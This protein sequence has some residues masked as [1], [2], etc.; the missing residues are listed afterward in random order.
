MC[1]SF[2]FF[3]QPVKLPVVNSY[4]NEVLTE[5]NNFKFQMMATIPHLR[6]TVDFVTFLI[7]FLL[8]TMQGNATKCG[9]RN[10]CQCR[11]VNKSDIGVDCKATAINVSEACSVCSV[12]GNVTS[13]DLG[14]T[15]LEE[16]PSSCFCH[17]L[18]LRDL[19]LAA[20]G[21]V[22]LKSETF[23]GLPKLERL[24]LSSNK[25]IKH[26]NFSGKDVFRRLTNLKSLFLQGNIDTEMHEDSG[27]FLGNLP[28]DSFPSLNK[29]LIDGVKNI[30]LGTNFKHFR[31]LFS[32]KFD[33]YGSLCNI[34]SLTNKTFAN[35]PYLRL[36]NLA[37][38][39]ITYIEAGAF[40]MLHYLER[41]N[42]SSNRGLG[43]V[44]L[45]NV[46]YGLQ[47]T[48]IKVLDYSKVIKT[49][50]PSYE[51]L[52]CD[53]VYMRNTTLEE[54]YVNANNLVFLETNVP[55]MFPPSIRGIYASENVWDFNPYTLQMGC[56]KNMTRLV[57]GSRK[58]S[59]S[60]TLYNAE[61][62]F[63]ERPPG[64]PGKC[65]IAEPS[66]NRSGCPYFEDNKAVDNIHFSFPENLE[67]LSLTGTRISGDITEHLE[68]REFKNNLKHLDLTHNMLG[69]ILNKLSVKLTK[70]ESLNISHNRIS[71]LMKDANKMIP[72]VKCLDLSNNVLGD[73]LKDMP[74]QEL[75]I[76][77]TNLRYLNLSGN[78]I[79]KL[80]R[81]I[82]S[83][84]PNLKFV[85]LAY[86][87]LS[88]FNISFKTLT[89]L[90]KLDLRQNKIVTLPIKLL[91]QI[92]RTKDGCIDLSNNPIEISCENLEFLNW[93]MINP[94][95]FKDLDS[96]T[97]KSH[98]AHKVL[99][100]KDFLATVENLRAV[101]KTKKNYV[102]LIIAFSL[103][104]LIF[105]ILLIIGIMFRYRWRIQFLYYMAKA[106]FKGY[107]QVEES[108]GVYKYDAFIPYAEDDHNFVKNELIMELEE[109]AGYSLC[110]HQRDFVPGHYVAENILNAITNSK[111]TIAVLS[112]NFL[113]SKW[114]IYEFNM[115]RMESIYSRNGHRVALC[116]KYGDV[117]MGRISSEMLDCLESQTFLEYPEDETQR[118]YFWEMLDKTLKI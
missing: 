102:S 66:R 9:P 29:L 110:I 94:G 101:C 109:K 21:L 73:Y 8:L 17:C 76:N 22:A 87:S 30:Q 31:K 96:Y 86:N 37:N 77:L 5:N 46:T 115:A 42:L 4:D 61:I 100:Q 34:V 64:I 62:S 114:C 118:P 69:R 88:N 103:L 48:N 105:I 12:V 47:Y 51:L 45:Q 41:L 18:H 58:F 20:N 84:L 82:F 98:D 53:L 70:L 33:G 83:G 72:N 85:S 116:I 55:L 95:Y 57:I 24:D 68:I 80:P 90:S 93:I 50:S 54:F 111:T 71:L 91:D 49:L 52:R 28:N 7:S 89:S 92:K 36:L 65:Q 10:Q 106:H 3:L 113:D 13:L 16:I 14:A 60:P 1:K 44:T 56:F 59:P 75:L 27:L 99:T 63:L 40:G 15:N 25:L 108:C 43:L 32:L 79:T 39:N 19:L 74:D 107:R 112:N 26:G 117:D 35:A 6:V 104:I 38:C 23:C 97:Y 67:S 11:Q 2:V 81:N 78:S